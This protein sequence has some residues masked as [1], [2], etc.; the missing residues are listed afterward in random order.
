MQTVGWR[1]QERKE[2]ES[3]SATDHAKV[4]CLHDILRSRQ[5][6]TCVQWPHVLLGVQVHDVKFQKFFSR[7]QALNAL[8][9][10]Y[11]PCV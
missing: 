11:L 1:K 6:L 8:G 10:L 2:T 3:V 9:P 5:R 4:A 7:R